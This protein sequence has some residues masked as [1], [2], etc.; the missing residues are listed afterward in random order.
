MTGAMLSHEGGKALLFLYRRI[1]RSCA[2]YPSKNRWGIY[3]AIREEF[4][5]SV[6][7][8]PESDEC[9]KKI[10]VAYKGLE[11]LR[12]YDEYNLNGGDPNNP[13]WSVTLEQNPMPKP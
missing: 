1:L 9:R 8:N 10:G 2:S 4:R 5:E 6:H 11:Q 12:M 7:L 3:E 13:N